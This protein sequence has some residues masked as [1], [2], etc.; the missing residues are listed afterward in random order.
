MKYNSE[1]QA[2]ITQLKRD[3]KTYDKEE[4][5]RERIRTEIM[6]LMARDPEPPKWLESRRNVTGDRGIPCCLW[7][8]WHIGEVVTKER[9]NGLNEFN[10]RIAWQRLHKLVDNTIEIAFEHMGRAKY[11]Y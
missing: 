3:I 10:K 11:T 8:D 6:G 4:M 7:T 9:T 2:Q 1:L 5:T